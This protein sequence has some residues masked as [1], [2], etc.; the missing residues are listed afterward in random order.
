MG[1]V[2]EEATALD[3]GRATLIIEGEVTTYGELTEAVARVAAA[4]R[5]RAWSPVGASRSSTT[6]ASC[7]SP[8]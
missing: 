8:P 6:P 2:L 1:R 5:G 3:P 4:L 7:P